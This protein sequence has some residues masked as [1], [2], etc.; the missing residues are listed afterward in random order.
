RRIELLQSMRVVF[1][2]PARASSPQVHLVQGNT[3]VPDH[4]RPG[5]DSA[6][7]FVYRVRG[8]HETGTGAN[9]REH[10]DVRARSSA[11]ISNRASARLAVPANDFTDEL[12]AR[13]GQEQ[14]QSPASFTESS[15]PD[16]DRKRISSKRDR[17]HNAEL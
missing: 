2:C 17:T 13:V 8:N 16:Q 7:R 14:G 4:R 9:Q 11:V 6:Y 3:P 1:V 10:D 5:P 12:A 15:I